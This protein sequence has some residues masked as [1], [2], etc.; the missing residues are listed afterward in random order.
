MFSILMNH[1][2]NSHLQKIMTASAERSDVPQVSNWEFWLVWL[3]HYTF[4]RG[5]PSFFWQPFIGKSNPYLGWVSLSEQTQKRIN[6]VPHFSLHIFLSFSFVFE[7]LILDLFVL[8]RCSVL[9]YILY[10]IT[11]YVR[12]DVWCII[13]S[14]AP[15][16]KLCHSNK[17]LIR[18]SWLDQFFD[19]GL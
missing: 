16:T 4:P 15:W 10:H 18:H 8:L 7:R 3:L 5:K 9:L 11:S 12:V 19:Q 6:T 13:Y 17:K 2:F 14:H 1:H